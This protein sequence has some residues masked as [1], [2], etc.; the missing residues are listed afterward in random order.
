MWPVRR[1]VEQTQI[2][3][4][5]SD[6]EFGVFDLGSGSVWGSDQEACQVLENAGVVGWVELLSDQQEGVEADALVIG[7]A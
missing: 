3:Q 7:G 4:N 6:F 1:A 2:L 5:R